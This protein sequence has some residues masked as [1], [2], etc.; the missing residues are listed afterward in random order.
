MQKNYFDKRLTN[1]T[2]KEKTYFLEKMDATK[3]GDSIR[4]LYKSFHI[5]CFCVCAPNEA[6]VLK[7]K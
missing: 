5:C 4:K 1:E 7:N 2:L 6:M 3:H